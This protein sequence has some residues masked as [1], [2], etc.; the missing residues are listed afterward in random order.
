M[1]IYEYTCECGHEFDDYLTV[2]KRK[3]PI[4]SPCPE[5]G[6]NKVSQK[7]SRTTMGVDANF[8]PD[9]KTGGDWSRL[10]DKMKHGTPKRMHGQFDRASNRSGG[11]L[12]P[13]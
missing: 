1:P 12:G 7:V 6:E 4:K 11:K 10:M 9:K 5:C 8:T 3:Q 2:S 13:Q